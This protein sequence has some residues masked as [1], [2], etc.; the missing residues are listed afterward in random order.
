MVTYL[1]EDR[2][3]GERAEW[4]QAEVLAEIN[5]D[6]SD[7]WQSYT[8]EDILEG[9]HEWVEGEFYSMITPDPSPRCTVV[10]LLDFVELT[11]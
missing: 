3:S 10:E 5:R 11:S 1:I 7:D 8:G 9:W 2:D 4:T 6:R